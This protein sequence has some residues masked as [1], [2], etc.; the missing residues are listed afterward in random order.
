MLAFSWTLYR[1][2]LFQTLHDLHFSGRSVT[3]VEVKDHSGVRR[4]KKRRK[5]CIVDKV[6]FS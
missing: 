4:K 2:E 1:S 3:L 5:L 6:L